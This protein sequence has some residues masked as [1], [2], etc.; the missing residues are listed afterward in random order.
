[1]SVRSRLPVRGSHPRPTKRA[2]GRCRRQ[3]GWRAALAA[4]IAGAVAITGSTAAGAMLQPSGGS[5]AARAA[6]AVSLPA[7]PAGRQAGWFVVAVTHWPIP[8][9]AIKAHFDRAVLAVATPAELNASLDGVT[10]VQVDSITT[11]TPDVLVFVATVNGKTKLSVSIAVDSHGLIAG[12]HLLPA[13]SSAPAPPPVPSTWAGVDSLVR[14]VAPQVRLLVASVSG[15]TCVP[16]HAIDA[17]TPAP[18]GAAFKLY[19]LAALADA[20]ASGKVSWAQKLTVT[21]QV[22]SLPSGIL[23]D[24]PDGTRL[25]VQQ[26]ASDM[27]SI[28]DN[29]AEDMVADLVGRAAIEEAARTS[30]MADPAL[31]VPF[32]TTR[33][34]FVLKLDDWPQLAER[35]LALGPAGRLALLAGTIDHDPLSIADASAWTAPRDIGSLEWFASPTDMCHVYAA[36]AA[37][38]RQPALAPV[39]SILEL[40]QGDMSLGSQWRPVWFKGGSEPGVL[41]LNYLATTKSGHTYVVSMLTEDPSAPISGTPA[42]LALLSAVKGAFELAA[43]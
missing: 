32:L 16:V 43:R 31:D 26:V 23:Q 5:P 29:T 15:G 13:G 24:D 39:A 37:L 11:S 8:T 14:S 7:T 2:A 17:T 27:I 3:A 12:L 19:V 30:G 10:A 6:A 41:T 21:S 34:L 40:N 9:A 20:V 42:T 28:S 35:Y 4:T 25:S 38:A 36:L 33:E 1:M 18:L 22:K